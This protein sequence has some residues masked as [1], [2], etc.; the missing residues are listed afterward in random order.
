MI[1]A[2]NRVEESRTNDVIQHGHH[3]LTSC[4]TRGHLE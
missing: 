2:E 4:P 3:M 1:E